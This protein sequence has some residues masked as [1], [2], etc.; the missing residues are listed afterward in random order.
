[1]FAAC[2]SLIYLPDI[3]NWN[4][5]NVENMSFMFAGCKALSSLPN[6]SNWNTIICPDTS[7]M[8]DGCPDNLNIP[9]KFINQNPFY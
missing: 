8:F 2:N 3:S 9:L 4:T 7:C 1:M 6:I 5:S